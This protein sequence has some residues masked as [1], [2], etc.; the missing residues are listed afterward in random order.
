MVNVIKN[1]VK[2]KKMELELL[3]Q[4]ILLDFKGILLVSKK[5]YIEYHSVF[6][7]DCTSYIVY[8]NEHGLTFCLN[9]FLRTYVGNPYKERLMLVNGIDT[10]YYYKFM[11]MYAQMEYVFFGNKKMFKILKT[12]LKDEKINEHK[13]RRLYRLYNVASISTGNE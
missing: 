11:D 12:F 2:Y 3:N 9:V 13:K 1:K 4:M 7:K 5:Y 6:Y 8:L 10:T